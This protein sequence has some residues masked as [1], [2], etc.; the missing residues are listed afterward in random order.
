M[1]VAGVGVGGGTGAATAKLFAN[2][3]YRVALIA[4]NAESLKSV[5]DSLN[6]DGGKTAPFPV[7]AY[8]QKHIKSVFSSI[9]QTWP[10]AEIRVT[11][12]NAG[13]GV[14][15]PFLETTEEEI[16]ESVDVNIVGAFA[17][18]RESILA[19]QDLQT[20]DQGKKGTLIFTGA[21]AAIRGNVLTSAFSAGKHGLRALS[22]SLA[23]EFGKQRI[24]VAHAIIDGGIKT[25]Q[26]KNYISA[27]RLAN[28][29]GMLGPESIAKAYLYLAKQDQ[30]AFTWELDLRP[31]EEKW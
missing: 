17:F 25:D 24:H 22:Q 5:S 23:K 11:V 31:A 8:T 7:E 3:G 20:D 13:K 26:S 9:K 19:F 1:V 14:F 18:A 28:P 30:S 6:A 27:E 10:D 2:S 21:T 12:F 4:R 15:K 29:A 16:Q